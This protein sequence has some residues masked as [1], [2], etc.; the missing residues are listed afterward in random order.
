[1]AIAT[2]QEL[3]LYDVE[4]G[5]AHE[6]LREL[7]KIGIDDLI[8]NKHRAANSILYDT[9]ERRKNRTYVTQAFSPAQAL[10]Y[11][12]TRLMEVERGL[13]YIIYEQDVDG[14]AITYDSGRPI[15]RSLGK[16][17]NL[18]LRSPHLSEVVRP[19][20][21]EQPKQSQQLPLPI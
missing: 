15:R 6:L 9:E 7:G 19:H 11:C 3:H 14:R 12:F 4:L 8:G 13:G 1:M 21:V 10:T 17:Q 16:Y 20:P 2:R 18:L 5:K